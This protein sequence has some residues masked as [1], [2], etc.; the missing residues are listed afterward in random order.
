[1]HPILSFSLAF[2]NYDTQQIFSYRKKKTSNFYLLLF[3]YLKVSI[4]LE[5]DV[6]FHNHLLPNKS[7]LVLLLEMGKPD[8]IPF[9]P[10]G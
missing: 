7:Y 10:S 1:M 8:A 5:S 6:S 9:L 3:Y 4:S 2:K